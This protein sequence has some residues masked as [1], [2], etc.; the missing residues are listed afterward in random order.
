M[1]EE[2]KP[3]PKKKSKV[4]P[5]DFCDGLKVR[6]ARHAAYNNSL[7]KWHE[8]WQKIPPLVRAAL[9]GHM[10][11]HFNRAAR[12]EHPDLF[13]QIGLDRRAHISEAA[14]DGWMLMTRY[15]AIL[16]LAADSEVSDERVDTYVSPTPSTKSP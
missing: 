13:R 2:S 7:D 9:A 15:M 12:A 14:R 11:E 8:D 1:T 4:S 16:A 6:A 3:K 10:I 5:E